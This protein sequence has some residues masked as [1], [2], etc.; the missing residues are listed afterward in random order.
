MTV[1][2]LGRAL[3]LETVVAGVGGR[4]VTGGYCGD[5]L[6]WVMG[7]AEEGNAWMTV[8]G[9]VNA[10]AVAVLADVACIILTEDSPLDPEAKV[11]AEAQG[12]AILRSGE[13]AYRLSLALGKL[14]GD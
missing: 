8:M 1:E 10:V 4:E 13:N 5:L 3:S 12:V 6:S 11:K 9:N 2:E 14:L 7:R